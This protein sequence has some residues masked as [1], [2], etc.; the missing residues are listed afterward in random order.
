MTSVPFDVLE[1]IMSFLDAEADLLTC[2][3]ICSSFNQAAQHLLHREISLKIANSEKT[4]THFERFPDYAAWV[5]GC[6][7]DLNL[8]SGTPSVPRGL[9]PSESTHCL[10]LL[11]R[12]THVRHLVLQNGSWYDLREIAPRIRDAILDLIDRVLSHGPSH[13]LHIRGVSFPRHLV[14]RLIQYSTHLSLGDI[15]FDHFATTEGGSPRPPPRIASGPF[16]ESLVIGTRGG[17]VLTKLYLVSDDPR[18]LTKLKSL[19]IGLIRDD[20]FPFANVRYEEGTRKYVSGMADKLVQTR[21][22]YAAELPI[23][24]PSLRELHMVEHGHLRSSLVYPWLSPAIVALALWKLS[25]PTLRRI[26]ILIRHYWY[27]FYPPYGGLQHISLPPD[28]MTTLDEA[29]SLRLIAGT[30]VDLDVHYFLACN[31]ADAATGS[32][33]MVMKP[34]ARF[35]SSFGEALQRSLALGLNLRFFGADG[36]QWY[37]RAGYV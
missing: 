2:S 37:S 17:D 27:S 24:L 22:L 35:V 9:G 20:Y 25:T 3:L 11:R 34:N 19:Q 21:S 10:P 29:L 4:A 26:H 18:Y 12:L 5:R 15:Y 6:S 31:G 32:L 36:V 33:D 1:L 30:V 16:L 7:L 13:S 28:T 8:R 23:L 14:G